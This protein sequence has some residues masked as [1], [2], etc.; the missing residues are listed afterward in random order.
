MIIDET[1]SIGDRVEVFPSQ[2]VLDMNCAG[3]IS[4]M[5]EHWVWVD[6]YGAEDGGRPFRRDTGKPVYCQSTAHPNYCIRRPT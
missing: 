5:T 2:G 3:R 6:F 1:F 4:R